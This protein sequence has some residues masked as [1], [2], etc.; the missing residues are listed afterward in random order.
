MHHYHVKY[1]KITPIDYI[2]LSAPLPRPHRLDAALITKLPHI[3]QYF[4]SHYLTTLG[5]VDELT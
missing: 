2:D 4:T 1:P 5:S 3:A